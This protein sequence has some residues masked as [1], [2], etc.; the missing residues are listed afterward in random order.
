[1]M[2]MYV[3]PSTGWSLFEIIGALTC[4]V[5]LFLFY[6]YHV[7]STIHGVT[8]VSSLPESFPLSNRSDPTT[9]PPTTLVPPVVKRSL[10]PSVPLAITQ[11]P[12]QYV[13]RFV[14]WSKDFIQSLFQNDPPNIQGRKQ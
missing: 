4:M 11:Q 3:M 12:A 10:P 5:L 7:T 14:S 8:T 2:P 1:M 6:R 9:A 13:D